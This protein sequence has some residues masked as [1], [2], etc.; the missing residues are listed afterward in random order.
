MSQIRIKTATRTQH[1]GRGYMVVHIVEVWIGGVR[2]VTDADS[3]E[4]AMQLA[5]NAARD[6]GLPVG[7]VETP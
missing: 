6:L 1:S 4:H 2:F 5:F 7:T 3:K